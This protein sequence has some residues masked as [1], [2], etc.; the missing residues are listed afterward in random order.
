MEL[1]SESEILDDEDPDYCPESVSHLE[2]KL[3]Q[4][5]RINQTLKIHPVNPL[6]KNVMFK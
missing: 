5:N 1:N 4:V 6:R 2:I 3:Y